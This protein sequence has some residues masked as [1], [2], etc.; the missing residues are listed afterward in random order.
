MGRTQAK[1]NS[2][3]GMPVVVILLVAVVAAVLGLYYWNGT[4]TPPKSA[5]P[6][7]TPTPVASATPNWIDAPVGANPPNFLG[8]PNA[9]VTVEEFADFQCPSCGAT[10]PVIK[11]IQGIFGPNIMLIFRH[12]PFPQHDK[13]LDAALAAEAAGLQGKFWDMHNL[14]YTNQQS[15]SSNPNYK[16]IFKGYAEKIG[17]DVNKWQTDVAGAAA[18]A[19][20]DADLQRAKF[21]NINTT[22]SIFINNKPVDYEDMTV[23]KLQSLIEEA[24]RNRQ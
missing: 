9:T 24:L 13:A 21:L 7:Q 20:I 22:P 11:Q 17:L 15:W 2:G 8:S 5:K 1:K 12:F 6:V 16:D 18:K 10:H 19:R 14:L 3:G 4:R 23:L